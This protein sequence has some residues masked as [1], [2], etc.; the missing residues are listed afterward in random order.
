M[1]VTALRAWLDSGAVIE[2][3]AAALGVHRHTM[4]QRLRRIEQ[5]TGRSLD[6]PRDHAELWL[7]FEARDIAASW[8]HG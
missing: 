4:R 7:A 6:S 5:A 8:L 3:A 2:T 1:S